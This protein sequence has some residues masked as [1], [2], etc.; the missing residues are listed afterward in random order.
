M[1]SVWRN[2][3]P[4]AAGMNRP[5]ILCGEEFLQRNNLTCQTFAVLI[6]TACLKII[7]SPQGNMDEP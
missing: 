3:T 1:E 7:A 5:S 2:P 6:D 4:V